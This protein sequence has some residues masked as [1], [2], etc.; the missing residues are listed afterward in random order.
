MFWDSRVGPHAAPVHLPAGAKHLDLQALITHA[1][2]GP[3]ILRDR[4]V[5]TTTYATTYGWVS[6]GIRRELTAPPPSEKRTDETKGKR[7]TACYESEGRRF[8]SCHACLG[9]SPIL[10][11]K[12]KQEAI[13]EVGV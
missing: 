8:G 13:L 1:A 5:S 2:Q 3:L 11:G 6:A 9:G 10:T 4:W 12:N 7:R